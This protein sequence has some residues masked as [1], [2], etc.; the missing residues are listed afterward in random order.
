[1]IQTVKF[2]PVT[3]VQDPSYPEVEHIFVSSFP[4]SERRQLPSLHRLL[5]SEP[6]FVLCAVMDN[7]AV[8]GM[9]AYWQFADFL[10][11]EYLAIEA[12]L[13]NRR[14]G[15]AVLQQFLAEAHRPVLLEV[16]IPT[17][18][19]TRRRIQFYERH[20]FEM[21]Q[22]DYVQPSYGLVPGLPMRLMLRLP[23]STPRPTPAAVS[24]YI[25]ALRLHVY[26]VADGQ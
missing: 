24:D 12:S 22:V 23:S 21:L 6:R 10:Y 4:V 1:M 7:A 18:A 3:S 14:Y 25:A 15:H 19:L 8:V 16:E 20:G 2:R 11:V 26:G 5:A 9:L 17:D 13:R